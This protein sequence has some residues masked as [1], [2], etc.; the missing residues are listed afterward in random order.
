MKRAR[1]M[2]SEKI[3]SY[4]EDFGPEDLKGSSL[5]HGL[6]LLFAVHL[7]FVTYFASAT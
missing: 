1:S 6:I 7:I 2:D 4:N 5:I 3:K